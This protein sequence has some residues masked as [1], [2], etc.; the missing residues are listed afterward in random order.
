VA[1]NCGCGINQTAICV[2]R[3]SRAGL[4][5][6]CPM[7][8]HPV[9]VRGAPDR[10]DRM[11]SSPAAAAGTRYIRQT[12]LPGFGNAGQSALAAGRVLVIGAGGL[13][14]SV[15]PALAAA[16]VGTLGI[17]DDDTVET[18]NL[19]RQYLHSPADVGRLKVDSAVDTLTALNP[20]TVV[21]AHPMRLTSDNALAIF[22]DYDLV[23]DGSDNFPTRYLANDAAALSGIPLVWGAV[24]Q[25]GGQA[26]VC[27]AAEGPQYRDLFPTPP[28]PGTVLS[29]ADGGVLPTVCAVIGAILATET[30]KLLTGIGSPLLGKVT[31]FDALSGAFREI[32]YG[33]D[34][35]GEPITGLIDYDLF[36]GVPG[37]GDD[38]DP[39]NVPAPITVSAPELAEQLER[40]EEKPD[41]VPDPTGARLTLLDVREPW[42]VQLAHLPG[43][44]V[45]P[46]GLLEGELDQGVAGLEPENPVVV[47]CHHGV[48]SATALEMLREHGFTNVRH[49]E[50][51][52][53]AWSRAVDRGVARY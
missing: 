20:D 17:I 45:V 38:A 6:A 14:S 30:I 51:G 28:L 8:A 50:G 35:Q 31:T 42:E 15:L 10:I 46:L 5:R 21:V 9:P 24:S 37:A 25:F 18:S 48:R 47:F 16:G 22:A 23:I 19:H 43:A 33:V 2:N 4:L 12:T 49:L 1:A 44:L 32:A 39:E 41:G 3:G 27:F 13:G 36:C 34:P 29:C 53:D 26:G 11:D 52:I 40:A 7:S